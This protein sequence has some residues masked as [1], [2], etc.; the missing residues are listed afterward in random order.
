MFLKYQLGVKVLLGWWRDNS[1]DVTSHIEEEQRRLTQNNGAMIRFIYHTFPT[2]P[3]YWT[4]LDLN[5]RA[6]EK[7]NYDM[8]LTFIRFD[9][10]IK[11][12]EVEEDRKSGNR[13]PLMRMLRERFIGDDSENDDLRNFRIFYA[14]TKPA[15]L[16][17]KR[18]K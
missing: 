14:S 5:F 16:V 15:Y 8:V 7:N 17:G 18:L 12:N 3:I 10:D 6:C 13:F 4:F 11:L 2:S 9:F 1:R